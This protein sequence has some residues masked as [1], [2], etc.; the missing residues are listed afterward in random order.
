MFFDESHGMVSLSGL[1]AMGFYCRYSPAMNL[2]MVE[3]W[4]D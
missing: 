2:V 3:R 4:R 1:R